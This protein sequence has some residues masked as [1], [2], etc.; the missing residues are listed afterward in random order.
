MRLT[1]RRSSQLAAPRLTQI[2]QGRVHRAKLGVGN[3]DKGNGNTASR[4][5]VRA[6][7]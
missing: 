1:A 7:P 3:G 6:R 2:A 4:L 5:V